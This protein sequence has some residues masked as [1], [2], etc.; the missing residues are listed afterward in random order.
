VKIHKFKIIYLVVSLKVLMDRK[1]IITGIILIIIGIISYNFIPTIMTDCEQYLGD[2]KS[3]FAKGL[4]IKC[5]LA[6]VMDLIAGI[7]GM[8]P[9]KVMQLRDM[10]FIVIGIALIAHGAL[11]T[12]K[13]KETTMPTKP[14][15]DS[16]GSDPYEILKTRLAKGEI[17]KETFDELKK[18]FE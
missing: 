14:T 16:K 6:Q 17:T 4:P 13:P 5:N 18:R 1:K 8:D 15:E 10:I 7:I 9:V 12:P 3:Y 2:K 11:T